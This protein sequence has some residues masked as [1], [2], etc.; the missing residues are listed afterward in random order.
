MAF[1]SGMLRVTPPDMQ[2][3]VV[4]I[5]YS[6]WIG[7]V[8]VYGYRRG[9]L[10]AVGLTGRR[11]WPGLVLASSLALLGVA[12]TLQDPTMRG[13]VLAM[14][15]LPEISAMIVTTMAAAFAEQLVYAGYVQLRFEE[16]FGRAAGILAYGILFTGFHMAMLWLPG[17]VPPAGNGLA[18]FTAG[19]LL[20]SCLAGVVFTY[21][22]NVWAMA[23]ASGLNALLVNLFR[24][25]VRPEE[26]FVNNP[27]T[28][29]TGVPVLIAW[30]SA[31]WLTFRLVIKK[32]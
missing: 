2:G 16:A 6:F 15:P 21:M 27:V 26:V 4:S 23:L 24:L 14:P 13:A 12:G 30:L 31:V 22:R 25:S 8:L 29:I 1:L 5:V 32:K 20:G 11:F 17:A 10:S 9:S 19:L 18:Q 28:L 3:Y 7:W